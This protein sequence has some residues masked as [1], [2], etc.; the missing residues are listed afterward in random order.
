MGL[1]A[2]TSSHILL[3]MFHFS[4][5]DLLQMLAGFKKVLLALMYQLMQTMLPTRFFC[6][7]A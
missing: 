6:L 4:L 5:V 1:F 7:D 3:V 2:D